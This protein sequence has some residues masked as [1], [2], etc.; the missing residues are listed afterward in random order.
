MW[1][2]FSFAERR[3][4]KRR[5]AA[6]SESILTIPQSEWNISPKQ[7]V[8]I[9][10]ANARW[11]IDRRSRVCRF[12]QIAPKAN[13]P[14]FKEPCGSKRADIRS[15]F[16]FDGKW[17]AR[18]LRSALRNKRLRRETGIGGV[19]ALA[20]NLRRRTAK[21]AA[22]IVLVFGLA[23]GCVS[24]PERQA[25]PKELQIP[26]A[27][28]RAATVSA[29]DEPLWWDSFLSEELSS[30]LAEAFAG[31]PDLRAMAARVEAAAANARIAGA[32]L[33]PSLSA[34][35]D[36][37]RQKQNFIGFPIPDN[38]SVSADGSPSATYTTYRFNFSTSWEIDLWGRVQAG[39]K[40]A[41]AESQA[42]L[43]DW[44]MRRLSLAAS[45]SKAWVEAV[46]AREQLQAALDSAASFRETAEKI[47]KRYERGL[48]SALDLRLSIN[49]AENAESLVAQRRRQLHQA[50][51]Q[52]ELLL[53]RYPAGRISLSGPLPP[54]EGAVPSGIP[55]EALKR[56]PDLAAAERRL[57]A[58]DARLW[59]SR[60][61]LFPKIS[62]T[63]SA[64]TQVAEPEDLPDAGLG[65]VWTLA[66]NLAQPILQWGRLRAG[67]DWSKARTREAAALY[68]S[69]VLRAFSEVEF[70]LR[71][72]SLL[73]ER[74]RRVQSAAAE[75]EAALAL[76]N[77]RYESGL[78]ELMSVLESQRRFLSDAVQE[79]DV[80]RAR[81]LNRID[82][83]LALGGSGDF[84]A[85]DKV[86]D[87]NALQASPKDL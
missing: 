86:E 27:W 1:S 17:Q 36:G 70:A 56:R 46:A 21:K 32:D 11:K 30:L 39:K 75:S 23:A 74:E 80:R 19:F 59:A 45:L 38:P 73:A 9:W 35:V 12:L 4:L 51:Q 67:V 6:F 79:I 28:F 57:A 52:V 49:S 13:D 47:E 42:S 22:A 87:G 66:G 31:N 58:A 65:G 76:A 43:A 34:Q 62:L 61:A 8:E 69:A 68:V 60:A 63:P 82:L 55:S 29:T 26:S 72:E 14:L 16:R 33:W 40:A 41:L 5:A 83:Y 53:G 84:A 24:V 20:K 85:D 50:L 64:G 3:N 71:S 15:F 77:R 48:R 2:T 7:L 81:L 18:T 78:E 44:K 54:L 10:M 37:S 25:L